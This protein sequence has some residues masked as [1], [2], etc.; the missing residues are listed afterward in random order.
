MKGVLLCLLLLAIS[1]AH[2]YSSPPKIA[3]NYEGYPSYYS[4]FMSLE[5]G[6]GASDYLRIIW[7][8]QIHNTVKT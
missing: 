7:P 5:T 3:Y 8:E 1:Q 6:I 2:I 4:L